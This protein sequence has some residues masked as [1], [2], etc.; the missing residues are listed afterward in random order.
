MNAVFLDSTTGELD[1]S[2]GILYNTYDGIFEI[3]YNNDI[4]VTVTKLG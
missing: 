1:L 3:K 4:K 2:D